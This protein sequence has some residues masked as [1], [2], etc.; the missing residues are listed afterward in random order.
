MESSNRKSDGDKPSSRWSW[1]RVLQTLGKGSRTGQGNSEPKQ[2][3]S[4][5]SEIATEQER[6]MEEIKANFVPPCPKKV[7]ENVTAALRAINPKEV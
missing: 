5:V 2:S 4:R 3:T 1:L 6:L 7:R